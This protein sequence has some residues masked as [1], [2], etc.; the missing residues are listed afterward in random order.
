MRKIIHL[1]LMVIWGATPLTFISCGDDDDNDT[2]GQKYYTFSLNDETYYYG[3]VSKLHVT[4]IRCFYN[5]NIHSNVKNMDCC[6]FFFNAQDA[7]YV[8]IEDRYDE[9]G[10]VLTSNANFSLEGQMKFKNFDPKSMKKGDELE[11]VQTIASYRY[12]SDDPKDLIDFDNLF[13]IA[14]VNDHWKEFSWMGHPVGKIRFVS[15]TNHPDGGRKLITLEFD[16]VTFEV[17]KGKDYG[18][19]PFKAKTITI[20]GNISFSSSVIG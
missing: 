2:G 6:S 7:P 1:V 17:Y 9:D 14:D 18:Y 3:G 5:L 20:N 10:N 11:V 19:H 15:F 12:N 8:Y 13:H 16:N 4:Y